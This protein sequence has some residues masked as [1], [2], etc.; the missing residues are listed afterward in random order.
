MSAPLTGKNACPTGLSRRH[1]LALGAALALPSCR[2]PVAGVSTQL[3]GLTMGGTWSVKIPRVPSTFAARELQEQIQ[4]LLNRLDSNL[5]L[6]KPESALCR[7]NRSI[8]TDWHEVPAELAD[9]VE[10]SLAIS[11]QT[12]GAFDITVAPL[13]LL[14][15]FGPRDSARPPAPPSDAAIAQV[16]SLV[17]HHRLHVRRDP[18]AIRKDIPGLQIDLGAIGKG[19]AA[20]AVSASLDQ[21]GIPDYLIDVGGELKSRGHASTAGAWPIG[22]EEPTPD[23]RRILLT[24]DLHDQSSATSGDYH[25]FYDAN[26]KRYCHEIDPGTGSPIVD[27]PAAVSVLHPNGATAD[28]FATAFMVLGVERGLRLAEGLGIAALFVRRV[29][30]SFALE[31]TRGFP[32]RKVAPQGILMQVL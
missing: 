16:L 30:G 11:R 24:I 32:W 20:D 7:F 3:T 13:V 6:W 23:A 26:G 15:G 18:P 29:P 9:I 8:T 14:W 22:I 5:S 19:Y 12:E 1:F 4:S 10:Q 28:A 21:L 2:R 31:A 27:G 17:G 25:N